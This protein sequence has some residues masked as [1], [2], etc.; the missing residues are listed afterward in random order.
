MHQ[1]KRGNADD[2]QQGPANGQLFPGK[3][4]QLL[5][6][7]CQHGSLIRSRIAAAIASSLR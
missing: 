6:K 3:Q 2:H 7:I 1:P 5:G 4:L